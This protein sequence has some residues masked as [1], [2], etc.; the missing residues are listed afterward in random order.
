MDENWL[1]SPAL[2]GAQLGEA[3]TMEGFPN[4]PRHLIYPRTR[5]PGVPANIPNRHL[6]KHHSHSPK[7]RGKTPDDTAN[8]EAE[9]QVIYAARPRT[10]IEDVQR[11][12]VA[13]AT[14]TYYVRAEDF[15]RTPTFAHDKQGGMVTRDTTYEAVPVAAC[16][17]EFGGAMKKIEDHLLLQ[18]LPVL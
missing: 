12:D 2:S 17:I 4:L 13:G 6:C 1:I 10:R 7:R 15:G 14:L 3:G 5:L 8:I 18:I 11:V 16:G 9:V